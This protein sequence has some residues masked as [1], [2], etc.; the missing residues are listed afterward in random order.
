MI[1]DI[2]YFK[3]LAWE[4]NDE[5]LSEMKKAAMIIDEKVDEAL[6]SL[7]FTSFRKEN[8]VSMDLLSGKSADWLLYRIRDGLDYDEFEKVLNIIKNEV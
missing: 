6:K 1:M 8:D 4:N 2:D 5:K 3:S 7:A